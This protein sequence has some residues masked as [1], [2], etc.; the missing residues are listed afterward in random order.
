MYRY[1]SG[2]IGMD[3]FEQPIGMNIMSDNRWIRKAWQIPW[4]GIE[5]RYA[6]LF[7]WKKGNVA[8]PQRLALG[9]CIIQTE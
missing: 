2:Q 7:P 9:V 4:E 6:R 8:K 1:D 3:D 5:E